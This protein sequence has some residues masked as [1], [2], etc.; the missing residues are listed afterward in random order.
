ME[1]YVVA[2]DYQV[3]AARACALGGDLELLADALGEVFACR[4]VEVRTGQRTGAEVSAVDRA[5]RPVYLQVEGDRV[6]ASH[7]RDGAPRRDLEAFLAAGVCEAWAL[8]ETRAT[9]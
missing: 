2:V 3:T 7:D 1:P 9:P 6:T 4:S 8:A 5:G